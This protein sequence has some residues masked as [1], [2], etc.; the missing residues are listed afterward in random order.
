VKRALAPLTWWVIGIGYTLAVAVI[1]LPVA[2]LGNAA[3]VCASLFLVLATFVAAKVHRVN[4]RF[5][6]AVAAIG[7]FFAASQIVDGLG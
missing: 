4:R 6:A 5:I 7:G 3:Y 2:W 1:V